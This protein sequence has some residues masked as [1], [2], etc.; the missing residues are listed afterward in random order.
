MPRRRRPGYVVGKFASKR[1]V[2]DRPHTGGLVAAVK[3]SPGIRPRTDHVGEQF[4]DTVQTRG[5]SPA[6]L[7]RW[8]SRSCDL[9]PSVTTVRGTDDRLV[10]LSF[11][12]SSTPRRSSGH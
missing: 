7:H 1:A 9:R 5:C 12:A 11:A 4:D 3:A 2:L 10:R 8:A 6:L